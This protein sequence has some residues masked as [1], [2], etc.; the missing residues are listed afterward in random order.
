VVFGAQEK[1]GPLDEEIMKE[2]KGEVSENVQPEEKKRK[3]SWAI[4]CRKKGED[5]GKSGTAKG[6]GGDSKIT[7][8]G[9]QGEKK[10]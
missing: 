10:C 2:G 1:W 5:G 6:G 7:L 9:V 4:G 3:A 8:N